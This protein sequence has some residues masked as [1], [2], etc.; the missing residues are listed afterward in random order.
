MAKK[1]LMR[2]A[3]DVAVDHLSGVAGLR[4]ALNAGDR[5]AGE[6]A[7]V[8]MEIPKLWWSIM[9]RMKELVQEYKETIEQYH[10]AEMPEQVEAERD[11][12]RRMVPRTVQDVTDRTA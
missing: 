3:V 6:D 2:K 11:G 10:D 12:L 8:K 7:L 4:K 1:S 9:V 5:Q